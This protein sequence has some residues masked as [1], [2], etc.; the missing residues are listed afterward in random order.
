MGIGNTRQIKLI[1]ITPVKGAEG[2]WSSEIET[3]Y[4]AW[5]DISNASQFRDY[6]N[7]QVQLG[8]NKRFKVRFRFDQYPGADWKVRYMNKDWTVSSITQEDEK[9]FYWIITA[10]AK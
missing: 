10:Q 6:Q 9:R 5:A 4:N 8:E 3:S 7:G 2:N 1:Q